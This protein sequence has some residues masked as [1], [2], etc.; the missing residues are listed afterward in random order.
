MSHWLKSVNTLLEKL[1]DRAETVAAERTGIQEDENAG[2]IH[3][4]L[5]KR[6][7]GSASREDEDQEELEVAENEWE[8]LEPKSEDA[9]EKTSAEDTAGEPEPEP[10]ASREESRPVAVRDGNTKEEPVEVP[11]DTFEVVV[12]AGLEKGEIQ[13]PTEQPELA[14]HSAEV[15]AAATP[16]E[17]PKDE[18]Q[19]TNTD[20]NTDTDTDAKEQQQQAVSN[21]TVETILPAAPEPNSSSKTSNLPPPPP[22]KK[23]PPPKAAPSSRSQKNATIEA[24]EA[25]K[26]ARTLR[27]HVVSLNSQLEAAESELQ[28]QRKELEL[29]AVRME[30][31]RKKA[32]LDKEAAQKKS[33]QELAA[34]KMQHQQILT[35]QESRFENQIASFRATI[36][37]VEDQRQQEGG[38]MNK[39]LAQFQERE[40]ELSNRTNMLE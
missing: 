32:K 30:K 1:D 29:A 3:D 21:D 16:P 34:L 27:R 31:D 36:E 17:E 22:K 6:G 23:P 14:E 2:D 11:P 26:E 37:Q 4:I 24:K 35:E 13:K 19:T 25:Q 20:T 18:T 28:A 40:Q 38:N 12:A 5:A 39:E 33:A 15:K 7:L 8:G 9:P 10:A